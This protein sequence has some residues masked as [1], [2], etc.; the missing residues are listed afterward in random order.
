[1]ILYFSGTGNS[2]FL[3]EELGKILEDS[4]L[5]LLILLKKIE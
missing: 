4:I 5:N 3:A 1:M 2:E